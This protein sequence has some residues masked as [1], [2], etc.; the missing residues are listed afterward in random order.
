MTTGGYEDDKPQKVGGMSDTHN[1]N[2]K[3][4]HTTSV[5]VKASSWW[6]RMGFVGVE[7]ESLSIQQRLERYLEVEDDGWVRVGGT[8]VR[9]R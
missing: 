7:T 9:G 5:R 1:Q 8:C 3:T 6:A 4:K 2:T